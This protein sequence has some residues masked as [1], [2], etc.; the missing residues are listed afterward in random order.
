MRDI[1]KLTVLCEAAE[2]AWTGTT[3]EAA[4]DAM[5]ARALGRGALGLAR[6]GDTEKAIHTAKSAVSLERKHLGEHGPWALFLA[7]L[8]RAP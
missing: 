5:R 1:E 7:E 4:L 3:F 8:E 2:D 6:E